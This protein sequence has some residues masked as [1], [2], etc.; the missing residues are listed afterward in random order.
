MPTLYV[1][2]IILLTVYLI[3]ITM[4][5]EQREQM[6]LGGI[7]RKM[8]GAD[9]LLGMGGMYASYKSAIAPMPEQKKSAAWKDYMAVTKAAM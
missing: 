4:K 6:G 2:P 3:N 8:K 7:M 1:I 9:T 5:N